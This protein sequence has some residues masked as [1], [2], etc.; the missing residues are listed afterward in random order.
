MLCDAVCLPAAEPWC[1]CLFTYCLRVLFVKLNFLITANLINH[2]VQ[3]KQKKQK[4]NKKHLQ[5][6]YWNDALMVFFPHRWRMGDSA[7][8]VPIVLTSKGWT[9][10][11]SLLFRAAWPPCHPLSVGRL[12]ECV[13]MSSHLLWR[14]WRGGFFFLWISRFVSH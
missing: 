2:V 5:E 6:T 11:T 13:T 14:C 7:H 8:F 1:S 9:I 12:W 4:K 3:T 10:F